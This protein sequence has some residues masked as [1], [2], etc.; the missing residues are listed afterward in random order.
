LIL[1][2]LHGEGFPLDRPEPEDEPGR[3]WT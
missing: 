1:I 3:R 2:L